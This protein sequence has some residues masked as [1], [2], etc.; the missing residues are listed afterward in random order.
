M[1]ATG[2]AAVQ[3]S[4]KKAL[5][6]E[7]RFAWCCRWCYVLSVT[8]QV[9][10]YSCGGTR[11]YTRER[12]DQEALLPFL[13]SL[14]TPSSTPGHG[15]GLKR[16]SSGM[17]QPILQYHTSPATQQVP[18]HVCQSNASPLYASLGTTSRTQQSHSTTLAISSTFRQ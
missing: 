5:R 11:R 12:R 10:Q 3:T 16:C 17:P 13:L 1:A 14:S 9:K 2:T 4:M 6:L 7:Q 18:A 8:W 15:V